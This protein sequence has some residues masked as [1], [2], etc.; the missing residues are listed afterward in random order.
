MMMMGPGRKIA[1][2][3]TAWLDRAGSILVTAAA[4]FSALTNLP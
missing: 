2:R 3:A 1:R 4:H